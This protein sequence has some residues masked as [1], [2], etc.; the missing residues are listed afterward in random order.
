M[1]QELLRRLQP[2]LVGRYTFERELGRGGTAVVF[3]AHDVKHDRKVALKV[4]LP[5]VAQAIGAERFQREITIAARLMHPHILPL[6][7]SGEADGLLYYVM[8]F[9]QGESLRDRLGREHQLPMNDAIRI[10]VEV[11]SALAKAHSEGV[12][13]RD[14]KPENILLQGGYAIVADFGIARAKSATAEHSITQ[15]GL[16]VGTPTYMSPEQAVGAQDVDGR[17]DIYSLGC[18]VY[19]MLA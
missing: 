10:G 7:D 8:P 2:A 17:S 15:T 14:I 9:V 19:E 4:L 16:A 5:Q 11:A 12:V 3:L 6:H 13:H 1:E 18:V